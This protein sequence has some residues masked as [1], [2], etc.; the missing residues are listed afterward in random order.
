M[1]GRGSGPRPRFDDFATPLHTI[2]DTVLVVGAS[3]TTRM[4]CVDIATKLGIRTVAATPT[5]VARVAANSRPLAIVHEFD[6]DLDMDALRDVAVGVGSE[7]VEI[8]PTDTRASLS[9]RMA[10][11][12]ALARGHRTPI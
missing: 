1:S 7:L 9:E 8:L 2:D 4:A 6:P 12:I 5:S 10:A 3:A 11:A